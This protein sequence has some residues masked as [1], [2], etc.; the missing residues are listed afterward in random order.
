MISRNRSQLP[1][2]RSDFSLGILHV[3]L[4]E[5]VLGLFYYS[6]FKLDW[7]WQNEGGIFCTGI[8]RCRLAAALA[9]QDIMDGGALSI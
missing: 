1:R 9:T 3:D 5:E 2:P 7:Q 4:A 6:Q 8:R